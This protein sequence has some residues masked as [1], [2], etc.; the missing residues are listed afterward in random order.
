MWTIF[1][2]IAGGTRGKYRKGLLMRTAVFISRCLH[3]GINKL[4]WIRR[5]RLQ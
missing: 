3:V 2:L 5:A 4:F 1:R